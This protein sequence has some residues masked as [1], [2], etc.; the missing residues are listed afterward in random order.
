MR[1]WLESRIFCGLAACFLALALAGC[2]GGGSDGVAE[3][4]EDETFNA[5]NGDPNALGPG[6]VAGAPGDAGGAGG[7]AVQDEVDALLRAAMADAGVQAAEAPP[8]QDANM[9][10]LGRALMFDK[11]LSGNKDISCATCHSPALG[12]GD[13]L[14]VSIGTGGV[15]S[16]ENRILG[17]GRVFVP[18]NAP[19]LFNLV[20]VDTL[21]WDGRVHQNGN[22]IETPAGGALPDGLDSAL[23]A[24]AMFPVTSRTEMRGNIGDQTVM[25]ETNEIAEI[26]DNDLP[27]QWDALMT[28]L[29]N[30]PGYAALFQTAYP[31]VAT[32]DLGFQ[33]AANAIAAFES[34]QF[35]TFDSPFDNYLA[36]D[37][38]ALDAQQ[39]QGALLFY[40][41]A[42]CSE[43]HTGTLLSDFQFHNIASPQVGPG[44]DPDAP[45]DLG[46]FTETGQQAD[47]FRFRTPPLRN[48][49][50]TGPWM[51]SGSYTSLAAVVSH[52]RNPGAALR[53]Y[54]S[55]Q[56]RGD[57]QSLVFT[58]QQLNAGIL[59]NL[60]QRAQPQNL[61]G[62]DVQALVAFLDSLTDPTAVSRA[63]D[64]PANVPSGLPVN[65]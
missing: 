58:Q 5:L 22:T 27:A 49:A 20:G 34:D 47:R 46:R 30:V 32:D 44:R 61:S 36:G 60:D 37:D 12:T 52:Y 42:R 15:G 38:S 10:E 54:N 39:K 41:R 26:A 63:N 2:G 23:A 13:A 50:N 57:L 40:G 35:G 14:S 48:V 9:V 19:P 64:I 21:F 31:G 28:R 25:S 4:F 17:A 11:I 16:G 8:A 53:N 45:L 51:H 6:G 33:H 62:P 7:V 43:C 55:G 24:Q 1:M 29:L 59:N 18:R 56:L 3:G 65:D